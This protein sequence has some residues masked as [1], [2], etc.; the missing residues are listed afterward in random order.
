VRL[1]K[2]GWRLTAVK[3]GV[4]SDTHLQSVQGLPGV[5]VKAFSEVDLIVHTGD[6]VETAVLEGLKGIGEVKAVRGNMDSGQIRDTLPE[7][8]LL[9][10][11]NKRIGIIHNLGSPWGLENRVRQQFGQVDIILHGHTHLARNEVVGGVLFFNPGQASNSYG[12]LR[13]DGDVRGQII[14]V[15]G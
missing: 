12:I 5:M 15:V 14:K 1:H 11:N 4:L 2:A 10:I 6:F 13:I 7:K 8:E 9:V 3:I